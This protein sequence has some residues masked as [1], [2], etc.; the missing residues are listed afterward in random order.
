MNLFLTEKVA[1]VFHAN[2]VVLLDSAL[3][4]EYKHNWVGLAEDFRSNTYYSGVVCAG[5]IR[6]ASTRAIHPSAR[7]S[8]GQ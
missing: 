2:I 7:L 5:L 6:R 8:R 1:E 4:W 3:N